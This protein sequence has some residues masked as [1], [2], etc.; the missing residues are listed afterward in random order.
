MS[1]VQRSAGTIW[2]R[3]CENAKG[4]ADS[5]AIV[6]GKAGESPKHW[7]WSELIRTAEFYSSVL[8]IIIAGNTSTRKTL[9][10]Q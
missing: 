1:H 2:H 5:I 10:R 6:H 8:T 3:W 7:T 9:R 4:S